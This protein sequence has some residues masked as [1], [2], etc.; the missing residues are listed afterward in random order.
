[1][2]GYFTKGKDYGCFDVY[3]DRKKLN[4]FTLD[5]YNSRVIN[6]GKII[7]G[8]ARLYQ[9]RHQ[10]KFVL[11]GKSKS[12]KGYMIGVDCLVFAEVEKEDKVLIVDNR[13]VASYFTTEGD[14]VIGSGGQDY[15]D[16]VHWA[17]KGDGG[18]KA[19]WRPEFPRAG[20][21]TVYIWYGADPVNDH[22]SNAA[23]IIKHKK[24][25]DRFTVNLKTNFGKW[26]PLGEFYFKKGYSGYVMTSNDAN[27]NVL[28]DAV[29]FV[30]E[31]K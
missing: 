18:S 23:F 9:G 19:F 8:R 30:N 20:K 11:T 31:G 12:S 16:N 10:L 25:T 5:G 26:N 3:L 27:G 15:A 21:Y 4:K 29:K 1:V 24:G 17:L 14:W 22:A 13:D 28:A 6:S 2:E 7:L